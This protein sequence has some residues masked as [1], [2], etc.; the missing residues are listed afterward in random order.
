VPGVPY[1]VSESV[2]AFND[3]RIRWIDTG[4]LLAEQGRLHAQVHNIAQSSKRYAGLLAWCGIDYASIA[5][6]RKIWHTLKTPGV[7]DTFRVPKPAAAFYRSQVSPAVRPVILPMFFWDFGPRSPATGP[8]AGSIIA[9]NCNRLELY[10]GRKHFAT[11]TPDRGGYGHLAYPLVFADL[12]VPRS[13]RPAL[14][15]LRIDG[16]VD[17]R[18]VASL[19]MSADTARDRLALTLDDTSIQADGTDTTRVTFR[20]LDAY[21]NQRPYVTGD[22]TLSLAGPATLIAENPFAFGTY[23]GVG[24]AFIRSQPGRSG[25]VTVTAQH[26]TLGTATARLTV[27]PATGEQFL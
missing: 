1:F 3:T 21:G 27:I 8:G 22:V 14:P 9:T 25:L 13:R 26:A 12:T 11:G 6:A 5:G 7:I 19:R 17:G 10:V 18:L 16:Y 15:D 23:G 2:G 4:A 20:A 24:G